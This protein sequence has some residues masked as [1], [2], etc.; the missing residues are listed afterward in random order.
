MKEQTKENL[1]LFILCAVSIIVSFVLIYPHFARGEEA[2]GYKGATWGMSKVE[3][4]DIIVH[5]QAGSRFLLFHFRERE[6][7][8]Q[9]KDDV[10]KR[11]DYTEVA[12]ITYI[13]TEGKLSKVEILF[14]ISKEKI[15]LERNKQ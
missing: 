11:K 10:R 4:W 6:D 13:F 5:E 9:I 2:H 15:I 12:E 1:W 7:T 3:V 8:I 14:V